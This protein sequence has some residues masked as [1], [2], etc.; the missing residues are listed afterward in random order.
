MPKE[1][2]EFGS[3]E[4]QRRPMGPRRGP[5]G[6]GGRMGRG[7]PAEHAANPGQALRDLLHYISNHLPGIIVALV[8]GAVAAVFSVIGPDRL[9]DITDL[10]TEGLTG[11]VDLQAI[12]DI[13]LF[14]VV[15]YGLSMIFGYLQTFILATI[16]QRVTKSLRGDIS[17][18]INKLP[19]RYFDSHSTGD[20]MSRVTNDVDLIGQ[21]LNNSIGTLVS[22]ITLFF[23]A[24]IMMFITNAIM[25]VT[26]VVASVIGFV[27]MMIVMS[28]S[29]KYFLAQQNELGAIDG[30]IEE[31]YTGHQ[32][33]KAYTA[34]PSVEDKFDTINQR[35][36]G[37]AWRA[38]FMSGLMQPLM[39]FIGNFGYVAVCVIGAV[40]A[41]NGTITFGVI[42]SFM[43]Y[44][45]LFTQPL[46]Q[47]AQVFTSLQSTLAASE[48]VF[49]FLREDELSDESYKTEVLDQVEGNVT[50]DHLHFG[51]DPEQIIIHDFSAKALEGQKVAIVGPT[52]AGKTTIVNLLMRFYEPN[53]G[54][55]MIDN[56]STEDLTRQNVHRLFGMV[57]QDTWLFEGT[58]RENLVYSKEGVSDERLDE[59]CRAV[60]LEHYV[61][62]LPQGYDT[63]LNEQ[64]T[65]SA[66]QRQL[67]T[68]ARAMI[69]NAPMIILDEATSSIDTRTELAV[70]EAMDRLTHGRTSFVIAHRLSTIRN[71]DLILVM[72]DGDI[73]ESG[74]H[75]ELLEKNG[76]YAEL[77]RSQ[78][79]SADGAIADEMFD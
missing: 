44:V 5:G 46:S 23:G 42:V 73:V 78:F 12:V 76:F 51:Y 18:K 47:F 9:A 22:A 8:L 59:V 50:F 33:V 1:E 75:E 55:I 74:T 58:L 7:G 52:G 53:S 41:A 45:R 24:L 27:I 54:K 60:G 67:V 31:T 16:T 32:T 28:H 48:R 79:T 15:L 38:Q 70:Q 43:V 69:D 57:L 35:L 63:M 4:Q 11:D 34:E 25:A 66:G 3:S 6:P 62:T 30:H 29:Q 39:T 10:I 21:T 20:V 77:Y 14:L 64:T 71:A 65:L 56:V 68:I 72:R 36:Y 61:K 2:Y 37:A 17:N 19:L 13:C 26:A 49:T 40:L